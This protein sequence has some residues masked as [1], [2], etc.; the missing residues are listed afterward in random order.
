MIIKGQIIKSIAGK[1]CVACGDEVLVCSSRGS[2]KHK[3]GK[4]VVGDFVEFE[5]SVI[6]SVFPRKTFITRPIIANVDCLN[7]VICSL[8]KPDYLM[9]D[10]LLAGARQVGIE[11]FITVNKCDLSDEVINYIVKNYS[12]AT[13]KIFKVSTV[14]GEGLDDLRASFEN[15]LVAF[16]GQSAV[17]KTSII[18]SL[19]GLN[20]RVGDLSEK[21]MRGKHTTTSTEIFSYNNF[22]VV[23][24]PG[25]AD[26]ICSVPAK[27]I[28]F[29]YPEFENYSKFCYFNSCVHVNEPD[30]AVKDAVFE[31]KIS[32]DR[33]NRYKIIYKNLLEVEN[34]AQR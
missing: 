29:C 23:D 25:F 33:Y 31:G 13:Q 9:L 16:A 2:I 19:F 3:H 11:T 10:K 12:I 24:T 20:G 22:S 17:G 28:C 26:Y 15:K 6:T 21:T 8:P 34:N 1:F 27:E 5:N 14:N 4:L 18:N 32:I 30:C 7:V